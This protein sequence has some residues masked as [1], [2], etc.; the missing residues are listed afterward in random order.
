MK[1]LSQR[2][3]QIFRACRVLAGVFIRLLLSRGIND[4]EVIT[5]FVV[6][7]SSVRYAIG[8]LFC[9]RRQIKLRPV[10]FLVILEK[11]ITRHIATNSMVQ[12][13]CSKDVSRSPGQQTKPKS[14]FA[15]PV[16]SNTQNP[17]I[18]VVT[19]KCFLT[20]HSS[21]RLRIRKMYVTLRRSIYYSGGFSSGVI[22]GSSRYINFRKGKWSWTISDT[23]SGYE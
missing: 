23:S 13:F 8:H 22:R 12:E 19:Y 3:G 21:L 4:K 14:R 17:K 11:R 6:F 18:G 1:R 16:H 9:T 2:N 10:S 7:M 5:C 15:Y 20:I